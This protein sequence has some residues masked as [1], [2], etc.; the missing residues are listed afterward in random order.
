MVTR[1]EIGERVFLRRRALGL[2]QQVLGEHA[3]CPYQVISRLEKGHQSILA[4]RLA[5]LA[6]AL[7]VSADYLLC[8]T[9]RP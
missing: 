8:R 7:A 9:E 4:E 1:K 3:G 6:D 5:A 2:T